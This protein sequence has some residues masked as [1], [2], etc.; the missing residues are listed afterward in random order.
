MC[1]LLTLLCGCPTTAVRGTTE[2]KAQDK[3]TLNTKSPCV[4]PHEA[5]AVAD[6]AWTLS[7][8]ALE[9][10]G[11]IELEGGG[12]P[13]VCLIERPEPCCLGSGCVGPYKEANDGRTGMAARKAG[14][15]SP[16]TAWASLSWPPVC[17]PA[18]PDE[19]H[20]VLSGASEAGWEE[21]LRHEV[22]NMAVL[23][24]TRV[25][26]PGYVSD[27]YTVIEPRV[28][29]AWEEARRAK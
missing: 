15:A 29:A 2:L 17:G 7:R 10:A 3:H 19:P 26:D 8:E 21:R 12:I 9:V 28:R 11:L 24:F 6:L 27:V 22:F 18:W 23:R 4:R 13:M 20:C 25:R 14:C 1:T 5:I 16:W